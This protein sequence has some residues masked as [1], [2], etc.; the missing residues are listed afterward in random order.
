MTDQIQ[1]KSIR[2]N[3]KDVEMN[4]ISFLMKHLQKESIHDLIRALIDKVYQ[5]EKDTLIKYKVKE[6]KETQADKANRLKAMSDEELTKLL[7]EIGF[8]KDGPMKDTQATL[9][10][11]I[12]MAPDMQ[13]RA[14][15]V[16]ISQPAP[17][18]TYSNTGRTLDEVINDVVKAKL[19]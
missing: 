9:S 10:Y 19:I 4:Q 3:F 18:P 14:E 6:P 16:T 11:K 8:F 12:A 7:Y 5:K 13:V 1:S 2:I 17:L 15:I